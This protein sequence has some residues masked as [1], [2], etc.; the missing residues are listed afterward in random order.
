M[1]AFWLSLL[2]WLAAIIVAYVL[3]G[4]WERFKLWLF[5]VEP[6]PEDFCWHVLNGMAA[7]G[8]NYSMKEMEA[9]KVTPQGKSEL[10]GKLREACEIAIASYMKD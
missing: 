8:L 1:S 5:G 10:P 7:A 3:Y 2:G 6:F 9:L 4:V